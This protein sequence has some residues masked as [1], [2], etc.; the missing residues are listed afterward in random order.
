[1]WPKMLIEL[2]PHLS[3][4][5]PMWDKFL[6]S[7]AASEKAAEEA[8]KAL[9]DEV[10]NDLG[11]VT[12]A[13]AALY[14]QLQ[15]Q[16]AQIALLHEEVGRARDAAERAESAARMPDPYFAELAVWAK[17]I[18]GSLIVLA[19]L[20]IISIVLQLVLPRP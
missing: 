7:K 6:S 10:R 9:T 14:R 8:M 20:I 17:R 13:H 3:R 16:S 18:V 11:Q 5:V 4:L 2:L 12:A 19:L 1:M 15:D